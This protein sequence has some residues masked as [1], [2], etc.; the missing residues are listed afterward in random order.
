[1]APWEAKVLHLS[2]TFLVLFFSYYNTDKQNTL[3][4]N[5]TARI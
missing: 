2:E 5:K 3:Y 1:M 4:I